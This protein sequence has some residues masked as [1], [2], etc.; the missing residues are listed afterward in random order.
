MKKAKYSVFFLVLAFGLFF[1]FGYDSLPANTSFKNLVDS[2]FQEDIIIVFNSGGWGNTSI[3]EAKDLTPI[4]EGIK[5]DLDDRGY[6]SIVVPYE[7]TKKYFLAEIR[8]AKEMFSYFQKQSDNLASEL[9]KFLENNPG[10]KIVMVGLSNGAS[11]VD[12]TMKKIN[13]FQDSILAIEIGSPFWQKKMDSE[14]ILRLDNDNQDALS[15]GDIK[16]LLPTL[17]RGPSKWFFSKFSGANLEFSTAFSF[18]EHMYSWESPGV[19][20]SIR[21]FFDSKINNSKF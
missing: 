15:K 4:I 19:S 11:F 8:G 5:E 1:L 18:P 16:T 9:E 6:K 13:N 12:E 2:D 17:L 7:R 3:E 21:S 14:N 20:Y 10:K